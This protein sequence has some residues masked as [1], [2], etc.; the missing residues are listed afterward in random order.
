MYR[1]PAFITA[2]L[3]LLVGFSQ[4]TNHNAFI[5]PAD[6][7]K[8]D[9]LFREAELLPLR[10]DYDEKTEALEARMNREALAIY[11]ALTPLFEKQ[12]SDSLL[13]QAYFKTGLLEQY[14]DSLDV[15]RLA[16]LK[17]IRYGE[18]STTLKDSFLFQPHL[19]L[20]S[21]YYSRNDF[22]SA[23]YYYKKAETISDKY[24]NNLKETGRLYN[25]LGAMFYETG[26]YSQAKNYFEKAL[27]LVKPG[28]PYAHELAVN[29]QVNI[30]SSLIRLEEYEAAGNIF[31]KLLP[32]QVNTNEILNNT[33][34]IE[35]YLGHPDLALTFFNKVN[36]T[37]EK[38][39][40]LY[41][42]KG[43]AF[44]DLKR[45]DSA[46]FYFQKALAENDK[47]FPHTKSVQHGITFKS[48]GELWELRRNNPEA[49]RMYQQAI[50]QFATDFNDS[51]TASNPKQYNGAYSYINLFNALTDKAALL[52]NMYYQD[53]STD[54]LEQSLESY[55]AAFNLA[56]YVEKTY[57]S[58]E[59]RLF[60]NKIKYGVHNKAIETCL[61]LYNLTSRKDYLDIIYQFDQQN[62]A[63]IL[64]L[65]LQENKIRRSTP[66]QE[67]LFN[68]ESSLRTNITRLSLQAAQTTDSA[69]LSGLQAGIRDLEINLDKI[70]EKI[71]SD[72][73]FRLQRNLENIPT[74]A[75]LEKMLDPHT[76]LLSY[77]LSEKEI[78]ILIIGAGKFDIRQI[79]VTPAFYDEVEL[80]KSSLQNTDMDQR[81]AGNLAAMHLYQVLISPL[82]EKLKPVKRLIIIPDDELN[83]LP[84]EA[85]QDENREYLVN[86]FAVTYQY[87]TALLSNPD[88]RNIDGDNLAMA[89]FAGEKPAGVNGD[90]WSPL[91]AS[92]H[93]INQ[94]KGKILLNKDATREAFL[95]N[96]GHYPVIHLATHARV[97]NED[98]RQSYISFYPD[99]S[100]DKIFAGEIYDLHLD[101]VKLVILSACETGTG[102][103]V[104]G[105]GLMSLSRAFAYA[106]CRDIITS[107]WKAE[108]RATAYITAKLHEH[109]DENMPMD[110]ALQLSKLE[111]L[112]SNDI[113]PRLKSPN[114]WAHL[115]FIGDYQPKK[116]VSDWRPIAIGIISLLMLYYLLKEKG[117][118]R[119]AGRTN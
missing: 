27:A 80:F 115:V 25:R 69:K 16:Y 7:H 77:H 85:L 105:E 19:F 31:R 111:L 70:Q 66:G 20:G 73:G 108:D 106:G 9:K 104:R 93:E 87:S 88:Q 2:V 58:D 41:N 33:G 1:F 11:T 68:E 29:Y 12:A 101:S 76:A 57:N 23:M 42:H 17:S 113:D 61:E 89:P 116:Q 97:N 94:L 99:S 100:G 54:W 84:F 8:A 15:S 13:A 71:N 48:L 86:R 83:Y 60:L 112:R 59:A 75:A 47:R 53:K 28:E 78:L 81:Y 63:S 39:I 114:Y 4:D 119:R 44:K 91:P 26:N 72:P 37:N 52:R 35:L 95:K 103:L 118:P 18:K 51:L 45:F 30:G 22:D 40:Q 34:I 32:E 21:I 62:K 64:A 79:P 65:N 67:T 50:I 14:F 55:R 6:Y 36:Y 107:L 24:G 98:P 74:P 117:L 82:E 110:E 38:T 49:L 90:D 3:L 43:R 46:G 109:M 56:A 102:Q 5:L 96:A 10:S 92:D